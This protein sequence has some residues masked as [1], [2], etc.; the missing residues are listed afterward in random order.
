VAPRTP[1][2]RLRAICLALPDTTE[3]KAWGDPTFR[4]RDKIFAMYK[5]GDG[6]KS[7]W[8]KAAPGGQQMLVDAD[9]DTFFVPPYVG[10][11]G[12]IGMR[13][14]IR[15]DWREVEAVV[16]RSYRLTAPKRLAETVR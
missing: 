12:W 3:K 4:V 6:R 2:D 1:L 9:P 16:K 11:K 15:L 8:C 7:F 14:D 10:H 5:V 13:L